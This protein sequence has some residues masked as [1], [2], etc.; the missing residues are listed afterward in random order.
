MGQP[1]SANE[2]SPN[3]FGLLFL[4]LQVSRIGIGIV[5]P[6]AFGFCFFFFYLRESFPVLGL[7]LLV[8]D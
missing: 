4:F 6:K 2:C 8:T 5:E 1:G 7:F 3:N